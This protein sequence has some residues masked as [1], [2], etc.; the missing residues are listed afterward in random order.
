MKH[1]YNVYLEPSNLSYPSFDKEIIN[2]YI[3]TSKCDKERNYPLTE[4]TYISFHINDNKFH[5]KTD[6][7]TR[8][9][10][11]PYRKE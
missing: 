9:K 7:I 5:K 1:F 10:A 4:D 3:D 2:L 11:M 6:I 8:M